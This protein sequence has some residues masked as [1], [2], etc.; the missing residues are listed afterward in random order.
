[1]TT[2]N[3]EMVSR[4]WVNLRR[5]EETGIESLR[6]HF[7]G[8]AYD[9]HDHDEVL[10]GVTQRT[11]T[12]YL[13]PHDAHQPSRASHS[14][15]TGGCARRPC[16]TSIGFYLRHALSPPSLGNRNDAAPWI[17]RRLRIRGRV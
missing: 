10:V 1:M 12:V 14:D 17:A 4:D 3:K 5:D 16:H 8:H 15:R 6:A 2:P 11:T 13:S 7:R 9:S